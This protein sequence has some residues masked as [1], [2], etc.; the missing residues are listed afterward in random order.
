MTNCFL[1]Q[2]VYFVSIGVGSGTLNQNT[3]INMRANE[4]IVNYQFYSHMKEIPTFSKNAN[5]F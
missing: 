1:L 2:Q 3:V 4:C 5:A